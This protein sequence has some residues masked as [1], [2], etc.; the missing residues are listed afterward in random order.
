MN[1]IGLG[2]RKDLPLEEVDTLNY[3][4]NRLMTCSPNK[5]CPDT[6]LAVLYPRNG[7]TGREC[8]YVQYPPPGARLTR[9]IVT[10]IVV[11]CVAVVG[12]ISSCFYLYKLKQQE[13]RFK[14]RFVQQIAR[15][16]NIGPSPSCIPVEKLSEEV[17]HIG[18][19]EGTI[20]KAELL[21]W[22]L[23]V[24]LEFISDRDFDALW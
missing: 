14:K 1:Y 19:N 9:R 11:G 24:K 8:G 10:G 13:K 21:Q 16:I 4:L 3:W 17:Q 18:N 22:M 5:E 7:G 23:D 2:I 15:N 20:T 12:T 6:S